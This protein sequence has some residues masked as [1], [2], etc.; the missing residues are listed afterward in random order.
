M[1]FHHLNVIKNK[2]YKI[3]S[4]A[5]FNIVEIVNSFFY[6]ILFGDE[7]SISNKDTLK[8]WKDK[9]F[10]IISVAMITCG[11]PRVVFMA[12]RFYSR[13]DTVHAIAE[14]LIYTVITIV[15]TRKYLSVRVRKIFLTL[16]LYL[17]SVVFLIATGLVGSGMIC[18]FFSLILAGCLLEKKLVLR[19]VTVNI[20]VFIILTV[21]LMYGYLDE[22]YMGKDKNE[23]FMSMIHYHACTIILIFLMNTIYKGLEKQTEVVKRSKEL[24]KE[25]EVKYK[26]MISNISDVVLIVNEGGRIKYNSPK[27]HEK[28]GWISQDICDKPLWE[29]IHSEDQNRIK[30]E[31]QGILE[32]DGLKKTMEAR[33]IGEAGLVC[34]MEMT[35]INLIKDSNI[36]GILVNY[37]DI[38]QRKMREEKIL[39]LSY[40][41][42]LTGLYNNSFFET[43]KKRLN[44]ESQLPLSVITGDI[45]GLKI[46]ND[47]LG[48]GEGDKLLVTIAKILNS[49]CRKE[50]IVARIGG[51]EFSILLPK[52]SGEVAD[53]IVRK[54]RSDCEAYNKKV[55]CDLYK[56]SISLGYS[57]KTCIS[58]LLDSIIK[59]AED[60]MYK[61]KLLEG[62]SFHSSIIS[63]MRS[64]LFEKS[65][66]TEEHAQ[67][68][69][70]LTRLVGLAIG[71]T[72]QEFDELELFSTLHDIGKIG[73]DNQILNKPGKLTDTEWIEMKKHP[74]IGYRIAMASP[75]LMSIAEY[76]LTHHERFDGNG[77]PHGLAGENIPLLSRILGVADAY[78]AMTGDRVYRKGMLKK[79]AITEIIKNSGTQF[80]P[81]VVKIFVEILIKEEPGYIA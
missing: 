11:A 59:H 65:Q 47:S 13:G 29:A 22:I 40:H 9:I 42:S 8:Y 46:I 80:D 41:D 56:I 76:I 26:S 36:N 72:S 2:L 45:N 78:D 43:A 81:K 18:V 30:G 24:L 6:K 50:D 67:R 51:G 53:E 34:Y 15:I 44:T 71:L 49:S 20:I 61:R 31:F 12:Y 1:K 79:D 73:T 32:V 14:V 19:V 23:W 4:L 54:I 77:Y 52:V 74:E 28:S 38:T 48:H 7:N 37:H 58:E 17:M 33:Y 21:L 60:Y 27:L 55:P 10:Y 16:V 39:Y 62:R 66:E 5:I 25:S 68:L 75:E 70:K 35:A 57:T 63:S 64:A 69:V 3:I